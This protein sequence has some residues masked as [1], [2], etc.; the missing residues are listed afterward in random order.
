MRSLVD[1][2]GWMFMSGAL[3]VYLG[4]LG[5]SLRNR[6]LPRR[7]QWIIPVE[8]VLVVIIGGAMALGLSWLSVF[9]LPCVLNARC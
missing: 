9:Y 1:G 6:R 8:L 3:L 5:L 4:R 7:F 2:R